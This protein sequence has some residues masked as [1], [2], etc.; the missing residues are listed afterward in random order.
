MIRQFRNIISVLS[1]HEQRK[2]IALILLNTILSLADIASIAFVFVVLNIYSNQ[3]VAWIQPFLEMINMKAN[4]LM[5]AGLLVIVFVIKNIAGYFIIQSQLR[6]SASI[7]TNLSSKNLLLFFEGSYQDYANI[8]ASVWMRKICFEAQEFSMYV[9]Y[10]C[11]QIINEILLI[12]TT[13][14]A[15]AFYN[16]KIL[17]IVLFALLPAV[18]LLAYITRKRLHNA[19]ENIKTANEILLQHLNESILGFVESNIYGKNHF[20]T[21]RY[22][23]SQAILNRFVTNMQLIQMMPARLFETFAVAGFFLLI[24]LQIKGHVYNDSLYLLGAFIAAAYKI[25][26]GISKIINY[27]SQVK[28]YSF[29]IGDIKKNTTTKPAKPEEIS[30]SLEKIEFKNVCFSYRENAVLFHFNCLIESGKFT[31]ISG[32]SGKGK[33]TLIDIILGFLSPQSGEIIFNHTTTTADIRKKYWQHVAY[34]RQS[35]FLLHDSILNNIVLFETGYDE[36]KLNAIL[37]ITGL[38]EWIDTLPQGVNTIIAGNGKNISGGQKQRITIARALFKEAPVIILD[39][40]FKELD[41]LSEK[42]LLQ[43]FKRLTIKGKTVILITHNI[44][45]FNYCDHIIYC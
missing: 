14:A 21:A 44:S 22:K 39:E 12:I 15:L 13:I 40:P 18:F 4:P 11:Q 19:R 35:G 30:Y 26:P 1:K 9:L 43:Y 8:D 38:Q 28:T 27:S 7:A 29:T 5:P 32:I 45:G 41:E 37:Q 20:F 2:F 24:V 16:I 31:G 17:V 6:F 34:V 36:K 3:P 42:K 33:T 23:K 25:I 10:S